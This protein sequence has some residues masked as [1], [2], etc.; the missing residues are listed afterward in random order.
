MLRG[1]P[2]GR[3]PECGR[4]FDWNDPWSMNVGRRLSRWAQFALKPL[5]R[6]NWRLSCLAAAAM[7]WGWGCFPGAFF[8]FAGGFWL[9]LMLHGYGLL[10]MLGRELALFMYR[11]P[12]KQ[13]PLNPRRRYR[14]AFLLLILAL[15]I[16]FDLPL[17]LS[18]SLVRLVAG[19]RVERIY[20]VDPMPARPLGPRFVGP[21]LAQRVHV[22]PRG[23]EIDILAGRALLYEPESE[24]GTGIELG[25]GWYWDG[26]PSRA[27][28]LGILPGYVNYPWA[29][30]L[31]SV[32]WFLVHML[33]FRDW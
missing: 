21:L 12:R 31:N 3:C 24:H 9:L 28:A 20:A 30:P 23:V 18:G 6:A 19:T 8:V 14:S 10:R 11:Q 26:A 33:T 7:F 2:T 13:Y 4:Q 27:V 16:F 22:S 15:C 1:L 17:Y 5:G 29:H 25:G 32:R